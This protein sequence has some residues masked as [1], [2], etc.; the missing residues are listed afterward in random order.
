LTHVTDHT[1]ALSEQDASIAHDARISGALRGSM[2]WNLANTVISQIVTIC[3][4]VFL[5]FKLDPAV[6]GVFALGVLLIDYFWVNGRSAALDTTLQYNRLDQT[7]LNTV[8]LTTLTAIILV[9]VLIVVAGF[10]LASAM[11]EPMLRLIVPALALTLIPISLA[12]P[13][14]AIILRAH[15]FK[16]LAIRNILCS[17]ISAIAAGGVA[18][19]PF[20]EWALVAQRAALQIVGVV[21]MSLTTRWLPGGGFDKVFAVQFLR[22]FSRVFFAQAISSSH[23]RVLD[24]MMAFSFG[25][26][27]VGFMRV[28]ARLVEAVYGAFAA[29]ISGLSI[30]LISDADQ[31]PV[32]RRTIY[33]RLSQMSAA[34][35]VPIFVG[36]ALV[37]RELVDIALAEEFAPTG[38][39]LMLF[40]IAGIGAPITY[41]RNA[42]LIALKKFN[43]LV[44]LSMI[45]IAV[46]TFA[47]LILMQWSPLHL[48]ATLLIM[49]AFRIVT[50]ARV[51]MREMSTPLQDLIASVLPAYLAGAAMALVV[52]GVGLLSSDLPPL[53]SVAI[54]AVLGAATYFAFLW[55]LHRDW[56]MAVVQ[57]LTKRKASSSLDDT[58]GAPHTSAK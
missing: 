27:A 10:W 34:V 29:P 16:G 2:M 23:L 46:I 26:A 22:D 50:T 7:S 55:F 18:L 19:S 41:A 25:T 14:E 24:L 54:K 57:V 45:D 35:C 13:S 53:A 33:M 58:D 52:L 8:F 47:G 38:P 9:A 6:F 40:C 21:V 5:T 28:A 15:D 48:V 49:E 12:L 31:S 30:L 36:M 17:V 20:P 3:V 1:P 44:G 4:F 42:G 43:L 32:N 39:M 51:M 37:S 56:V 11:D